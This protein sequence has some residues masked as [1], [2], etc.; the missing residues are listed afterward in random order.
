MDAVQAVGLSGFPPAKLMHNIAK[1]CV[2]GGR[3][4]QMNNSKKSW[5]DVKPV[6]SG[7]SSVQLLGLV[8]DLYRLNAGNASFVHARFLSENTNEGHLEPYKKRIQQAIC[9][10]QPWKQYVKLA[11]P[12]CP[13]YPFPDPQKGRISAPITPSPLPIEIAVSTSLPLHPFL[14]VIRSP[15]KVVRSSI[16]C[17]ASTA[18]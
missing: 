9:P 4:Q 11:D 7:F 10:K 13:Q 3:G 14:Q 8:Q 5:K 15:S 6:L 2:V 17:P 12:P 16:D 18:T 1:S